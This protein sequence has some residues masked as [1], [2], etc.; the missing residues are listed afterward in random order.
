MASAQGRTLGTLEGALDGPDTALSVA[1]Q[2]LKLVRL[3]VGPPAVDTNPKVMLRHE[4]ETWARDGHGVAYR[5]RP[6]A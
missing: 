5:P 2:I 1:G 6:A 3:D 4:A